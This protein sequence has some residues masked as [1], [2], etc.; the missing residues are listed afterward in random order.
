MDNYQFN[1]LPINDQAAYTW[2]NGTYLVQLTVIDGRGAIASKRVPITI[3]NRTDNILESPGMEGIT[4]IYALIA[5]S[6][7]IVKKRH[8]YF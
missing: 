2:E 4:A 6:L 8:I 1:L 7:L 5:I 3:K